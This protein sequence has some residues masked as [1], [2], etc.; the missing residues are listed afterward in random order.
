MK[1]ITLTVEL[2]DARHG[3]GAVHQARSFR[4][5]LRADRVLAISLGP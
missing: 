5:V 4:S 1:R 3:A 2:T